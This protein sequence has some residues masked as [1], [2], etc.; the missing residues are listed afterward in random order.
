MAMAAAQPQRAPLDPRVAGD[1]A[2]LLHLLA[3]S[4][5]DP[6]LL[7]AVAAA[8]PGV[9][10]ALPLIAFGGDSDGPGKGVATGTAAAA[11]AEP[12]SPAAAAAAEARPAGGANPDDAD[13]ADDDDGPACAVCLE[14]LIRGT[15]VRVLPCQHFFHPGCIDPWL[16]G[17]HLACPLCKRL[18][19]TP[20]DPAAGDAAGGDAATVAAVPWSPQAVALTVFAGAPPSA[21]D[22]GGDDDDDASLGPGEDD[23][24][25]GHGGAPRTAEHAV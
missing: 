5:Q 25:G 19:I 20:H 23:G 16:L 9:V 21:P 14:T 11:A 2:R 8:M 22:N 1:V 17:L 4:P 24:S 12:A 18:V 13:A 10:A 15:A 7:A 6:E 3:A